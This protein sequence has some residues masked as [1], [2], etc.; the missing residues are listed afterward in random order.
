[1][2][3]HRSSDLWI[4][5]PWSRC[6][7]RQGVKRLG[8]EG[9]RQADQGES[10]YQQAKVAQCDVVEA[11]DKEQV[12]DDPGEPASDEISTKLRPQADQDS[13]IS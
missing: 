1:V 8:A 13:G 12:Q 11:G 5:P 7:S 2:G 10:G 3:R 9:L 4:E 6:R